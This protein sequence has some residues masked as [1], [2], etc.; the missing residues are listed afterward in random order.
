LLWRRGET[1][2]EAHARLAALL[3]DASAQRAARD[4]V[5]PLLADVEKLI[6]RPGRQEFSLFM[7]AG[8]LD[9]ELIELPP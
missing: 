9:A 4:T 8:W 5:H 1:L 2:N 6:P 7:W 3:P